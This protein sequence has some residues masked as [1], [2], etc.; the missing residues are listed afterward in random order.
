MH[1]IDNKCRLIGKLISKL[2]NVSSFVCCEFMQLD[3][4]WKELEKDRKEGRKEGEILYSLKIV[5]CEF[6]NILGRSPWVHFLSLRF[7]LGCRLVTHPW[8]TCLMDDCMTLF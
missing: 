3:L 7:S 5:E 8:P 1:Q 4:Y 2:I 6:R